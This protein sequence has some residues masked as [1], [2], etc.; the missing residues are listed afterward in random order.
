M[1]VSPDGRIKNVQDDTIRSDDGWDS[2]NRSEDTWGKNARDKVYLL[3]CFVYLIAR[4][5][6]V[7]LI[8][9]SFWSLPAEAYT[10]VEWLTN[11]PLLN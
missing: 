6:L 7:L 3:F 4:M 8:V 5:L 1:T 9:L 11:L 2:N 10:D